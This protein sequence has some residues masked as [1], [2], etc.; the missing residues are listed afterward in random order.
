MHTQAT[1]ARGLLVQFTNALPA[2]N[3]IEREGRG[4]FEG[5]GG[6]RC[7][8]FHPA[9]ARSTD[10]RSRPG[11]G[12]WGKSQPRSAFAV[13]V[14]FWQPVLIIMFLAG[15][16]FFQSNSSVCCWCFLVF[17]FFCPYWISSL[18]FFP[19]GITI[20]D[21]LPSAWWQTLSRGSALPVPRT[22]I[23]SRSPR[24]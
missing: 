18:F 10:K 4:G 21:K 9:G 23:A 14:C 16:G 20:D 22:R 13:S 11:R 12:S 17:F 24:W 19:A 8:S 15:G 7:K 1:T 5:E 6:G 2:G 3:M